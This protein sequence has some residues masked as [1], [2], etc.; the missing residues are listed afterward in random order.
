MKVPAH[1]EKLY[2]RAISGKDSWAAIRCHCIQ[3]FG[4]NAAEVPGCT[5]PD[6]PLFPYRLGYEKTLQNRSIESGVP[7]NGSAQ[8]APKGVG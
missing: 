1:H 5:S 7:E 4:W 3:C 6:C 8:D 2:Q